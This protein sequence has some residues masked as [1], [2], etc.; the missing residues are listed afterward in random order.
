MFGAWPE[1]I[2][3]LIVIIDLVE[4]GSKLKEKAKKGR[5]IRTNM[6]HT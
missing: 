4:G 6:P 5:G 1:L 3:I 2:F